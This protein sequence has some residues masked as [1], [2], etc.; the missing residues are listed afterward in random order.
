MRNDLKYHQIYQ[1]I[2]MKSLAVVRL[3]VDGGVMILLTTWVDSLATDFDL[4]A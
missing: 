3:Y 2:N 1:I 4:E